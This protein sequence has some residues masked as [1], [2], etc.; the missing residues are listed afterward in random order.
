MPGCLGKSLNIRRHLSQCHKHLTKEDRSRLIETYDK[1]VLMKK[2]QAADKSEKSNRYPFK[3]CSRCS[4]VVRRLDVHVQK[5]HHAPRKSALYHQILSESL[6]TEQTAPE[7]IVQV[8]SGAVPISANDGLKDLLTDYEAYLQKCTALSK[9]S[10]Q[11]HVKALQNIMYMTGEEL[12]PS[13]SASAVCRMLQDMDRQDPP[14]Y[15]PSKQQAHSSCYVRKTLQSSNR[16]IY[17]FD[18]SVGDSYQLTDGERWE[19]QRALLS[20]TSGYSFFLVEL[21]ICF[22]YQF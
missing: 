20:M 14:G 6:P 15:L 2:P 12:L 9:P 17:F 4:K 3:R 7:E 8:A 10:V 5:V 22:V 11:F 19:T 16:V 21:G 18:A 13:L 1:F